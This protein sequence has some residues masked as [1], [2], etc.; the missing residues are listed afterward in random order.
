MLYLVNPC[1]SIASIRKSLHLSQEKAAFRA[2][3]SVS[4]W[5]DIEYHFQNVT[6]STIENVS[7]A[8]NISPIA[9]WLLSLSDE[10][11]LSI[12]EKTKQL[13][14][15]FIPFRSNTN[16]VLLRNAFGLSQRKL[17][18]LAH[19]SPARL[20]DIEHGCANVS[21]GILSRLVAVFNLSLIE[22]ITLNVPPEL[23]LDMVH[24]AR[25]L[26]KQEN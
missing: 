14:I 1:K 19:I 10:S 22:F 2:N 15:N 7:K 23:I 11:I 4:R 20:R 26:I 9:L 12:L 24:K 25:D 3:L 5:K 8:L 17:A 18:R 6:I 21:I 13:P 16:I